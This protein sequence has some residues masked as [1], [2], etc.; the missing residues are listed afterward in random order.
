MEC[1][2]YT[3]T[4]QQL[5]GRCVLNRRDLFRVGASARGVKCRKTAGEVKIMCVHVIR[6]GGKNET[7]A[8]ATT[9]AAPQPCQN[10]LLSP[11]T[12]EF[13]Q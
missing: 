2:R 7:R 3:V 9:C 12:R 6:A 8:A 10:F 5:T 11:T 4:Q 13:F 1:L